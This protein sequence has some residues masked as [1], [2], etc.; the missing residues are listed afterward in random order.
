MNPR[1]EKTARARPI[2]RSDPGIADLA[3]GANGLGEPV[4]PQ[5]LAH[6]LMKAHL[7]AMN[8]MVTASLS[9]TTATIKVMSQMWSVGMPKG[10]SDREEDR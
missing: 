1:P 8:T 2:K 3:R 7:S 4:D 5:D 9:V 10:R 6:G